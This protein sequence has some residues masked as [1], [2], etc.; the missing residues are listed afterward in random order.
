MQQ[1][2]GAIFA[3]PMLAMMVLFFLAPLGVLAVA[4][5]T[6]PDGGLTLDN[7][8][9]FLGDTFAVG[10]L[11]DTIMLGVKTVAAVTLLGVPVALLYWHSGPRMRLLILLATLLPM[12]TS[13]VVRTFAWIVILGRNG[14]ISQTF[15]DLGLSSRPFSLLFSETGLV[16]ALTQIEL[17]LLVLP[18]IAVLSGAD[19]RLVDASE[20][21]GAH[22]WRSFF[23]VLLPMMT[24]AILAGWV[25]VFASAT[26]SFVTHSVIGGARL[27]Y[28]PQ[29]VYREV[30]ILFQWPMAAAIS[31]LLLVSTGIVMLCVT[32]LARHRRLAAYA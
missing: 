4:S 20:V 10:V 8:R 6:G 22:R 15:V 13:N 16:M 29:F 21:L 1:R 27:I 28:M 7:Y 11:R 9:T 12:L 2:T 32:A 3:T 19:R 31:F 25:L 17:P 5:V 23:T 18:L 14:P 24:P 30:G 26:T